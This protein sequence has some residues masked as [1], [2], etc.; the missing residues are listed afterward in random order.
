MLSTLEGYFD[1]NVIKI[2][3][4][5]KYLC[6]VMTKNQTNLKSMQRTEMLIASSQRARELAEQASAYQRATYG[7]VG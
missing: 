4:P 6:T 5:T 1:C 2:A 3:M 7:T